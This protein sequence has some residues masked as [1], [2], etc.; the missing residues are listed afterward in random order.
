M[1]RTKRKPA[2]YEDE[3]YEEAR[4][5]GKSQKR[6]SSK[7]SERRTKQHQSRER[8]TSPYDQEERHQSSRT[9]RSPSTQ[10]VSGTVTLQQQLQDMQEAMMSMHQ[11]IQTLKSPASTATSSSPP[12]P[13]IEEE[14]DQGNLLNDFTMPFMP[15][16][17]PVV[18][19]GVD[20]AAHITAA[21]K[22]KIWR[23]EYVE[24]HHLLP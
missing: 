8:S 20:I 6:S 24:L 11:E 21:M 16:P 14:T 3:D 13:T 19:A 18:S 15:M 9:S 17:R 23:D 12:P 2:R 4:S 10:S 22:A 1:G 5:R 7:Q